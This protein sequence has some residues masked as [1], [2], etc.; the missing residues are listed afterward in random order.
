VVFRSRAGGSVERIRIKKT[1]A[2]RMGMGGNRGVRVGRSRGPVLRFSYSASSP[3]SPTRYRERG[4]SICCGL[5]QVEVGSGWGCYLGRS[6]KRSSESE[7]FCESWDKFEFYERHA[8]RGIAGI[9]NFF[10]LKGSFWLAV[11][12]LGAQEGLRGIKIE[13]FLCCVL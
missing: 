6:S 7:G 3:G 2:V 13:K 5:I 9:L 8:P 11:G 10:L 1:K 4:P 12:L